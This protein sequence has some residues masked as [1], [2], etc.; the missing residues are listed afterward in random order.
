MIEIVGRPEDF[1]DENVEEPTYNETRNRKRFYRDL[2]KNVIGGV[3]T[4]LGA[5]FNIDPVI[6]R[7]IF[8]ILSFPLAGFPL[9]VYLI[10]WI[11][12]P[13]A[14]TTTQKME[15]SGGNFTIS[16]IENRVKTEYENVKDNFNRFKDSDRYQRGRRNLNTA[17]NGFA[18]VIN[19]FGRTILIIIGVVLIIAGISLITSMFG[20]FVFSDSLLFWTHTDQ[21]HFLIPDFLFSVVNPKSILLATISLIIFITAPIIAIIYWGLKLILRF[22]ANDEVISIIGTVAW[23]LSIIILL[24]ITLFEVKEYAFST[25]ID[26][27]VEMNLPESQTLYIESSHNMVEFSEVFFFD[28]GLEV[29]THKDYPDRIYLEPD[30]RIRYTSDNDI[31]IKFEKEARGSTSHL[32]RQNTTNIEFNWHLQDS[33]LYIDPLFFYKNK[34]RWTFPDLEIILYLPKNQK[35]C[36]D[37]NLKQ[38]LNHVQTA[39]DIWTSEIP[40]KCWVMTKDGLDYPKE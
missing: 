22:R 40:G 7:V 10:L 20:V 6:L 35:I 36:I 5:Y 37:K 29:Y 18:E 28:E 39:D 4:G 23:I 38:T 1:A 13:A 17:G 24:G 25:Q 19:F 27:S 16:D 30:F 14:L 15:M 3:C 2:D 8:V 21:H 11:A 34:N 26:E 32:A 31:S 33:V 12:I 9:A